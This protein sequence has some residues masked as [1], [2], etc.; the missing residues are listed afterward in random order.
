M[1]ASYRVEKYFSNN[2][3]WVCYFLLNNKPDQDARGTAGTGCKLY[4]TKEK[5]E[6]AGKRYISKMQINGFEIAE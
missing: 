5:A 6:A 2:G 3:E 1:K 4:S